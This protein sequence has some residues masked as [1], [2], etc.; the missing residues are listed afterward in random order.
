MLGTNVVYLMSSDSD[1][2]DTDVSDDGDDVKV[3][4]KTKKGQSK[5]KDQSTI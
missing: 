2:D 5:P 3:E 4:L 1:V